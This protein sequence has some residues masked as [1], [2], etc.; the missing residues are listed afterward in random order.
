MSWKVW[1]EQGWQYCI[2][3]SV[4]VP[5]SN[6]KDRTVTRISFTIINPLERSTTDLK[7][8]STIKALHSI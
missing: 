6:T 1:L 3:A 4:L 7:N 5:L 2:R 8:A